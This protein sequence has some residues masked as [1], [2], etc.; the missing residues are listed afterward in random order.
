MQHRTFRPACMMAA[1][2]A[3]LCLLVNPAL[4]A[5]TEKSDATDS[6]G[7]SASVQSGQKKSDTHRNS[8]FISHNSADGILSTTEQMIEKLVLQID[9]QKDGAQDIREKR[10]P[11]KPAQLSFPTIKPITGFITSGFGMRVHPIFKRL[12]FHAGTDFSAPVGT[13]VIA[14]GDGVVSFSGFDRGYG[15]KVILDHG[16][17]YQTVYAHLSKA[18]I[19]QGQHVKRGE[20]IA[21][22]GNTG[23]STGPHLHYEVLKDNIK[24]NPTAFFFDDKN[25][26]RFMT[27][28]NSDPETEHS[29]S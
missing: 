22:S 7:S 10:D 16:N 29:N 4:G 28:H 11:N 6:K 26:D 2:L 24:V 27:I 12:M 9:A 25:P 23:N 3:L 18:L 1:A 14:T 20:V 8:G 13:N 19:R 5:S 17:G 21:F 15:K